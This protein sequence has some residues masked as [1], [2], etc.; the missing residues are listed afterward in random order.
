[1][2]QDFRAG[3]GLGNDDRSYFAVDAQGV[4]LAAIQ[5]L[6][7]RLAEQQRKIDDLE[8][9]NRRLERRLRSNDSRPAR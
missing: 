4:A 6:D 9:Q 3:F 7:R 1:M 2:A 5:A 8:R